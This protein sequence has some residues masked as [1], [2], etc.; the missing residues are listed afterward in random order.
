MTIRSLLYA[1]WGDNKKYHDVWHDKDWKK[2]WK[3]WKHEKEKEG[4]E[5]WKGEDGK[6]SIISH[7]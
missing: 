3:K 7:A 5:K 6:V 1:E 2:K 4:G